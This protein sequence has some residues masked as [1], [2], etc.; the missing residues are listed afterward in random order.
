MTAP[1]VV[2]GA[3]LAGL[4]C[5]RR[6]TEAGRAVRVLE[7]SD[8]VGGRVRTDEFDGFRLDRGFQVLLTAYPEAQR[9]FDYRALD[10]RAF[11]PGAQIQLGAR[12]YLVAD[13]F[14]HPVAAIGTLANPIGTVADKLRVLT[15]RHRARLGSLEALFARPETT[16]LQAL[17]ELG[18]GATMIDR[19]F[20][21]FLGGI[22]LGRNLATSSRMLEFVI[23]M[24]ADGDTTLPAAGM[25]A[26]PAQLLAHLRA[27]TVRLHA[28]V[29]AIA[30]GSVTL[31]GGEVVDASAVVIATEG[32]VAARL[33]GA[34]PLP[35]AR[36]VTTLYYAATRSP[37]APGMLA[38]NGDA[39]GRINSVCSP[40]DLSAQYAPAGQ[41]LLSVSVLG[42]PSEPDAVL[43]PL[44]RAELTAWYGADVAG[45][46]HLRTYR[47]RWGQPEQAPPALEPVE[48][49]VRLA[50][51]LYVCG[52]HRETAS[53]HGA[54][55]SGLR[56]AEAVLQ[57]GVAA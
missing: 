57:E 34:K 44:I 1:V 3:G 50:E 28:T 5:A 19:F 49:P 27:D 4:A 18:F 48:R 33:T 40:S 9:Q 32:D 52:D 53:I 16:T 8:G 7:A 41:V 2:V 46:R 35:P 23:R 42:T 24:M 15:L 22:F 6:L 11:Y 12:T 56:A 13:P 45:W 30:P 25:G 17:T 31:A 29:T 20:R 43:E 51:R 26:L 14:R 10:L 38:L 36:S 39:T 47:I 21:P 37:L 55:R 54:L